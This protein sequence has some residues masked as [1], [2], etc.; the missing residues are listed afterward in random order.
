MAIR[1]IRQPSDTPNV[2]NSDDARMV[3]YA[4]G[5][6]DGFVLN[7]GSELSHTINGNIFKINSG[8]VVLQ[9]YESELDSNGWELDVGSTSRYYSVYYEVNLATQTTAIKSVYNLSSYPDIPASDD[10]T[11]SA[12]GIAYLLLYQ[13]RVVNNGITDVVKKVK[14]IPYYRED[15]EALENGIKDGSVIAYKAKYSE[16]AELSDNSNKIATTEF[17]SDTL[18]NKGLYV[19]SGYVKFA[20]KNPSLAA[21]QTANYYFISEDKADYETLDQ[22][23]DGMKKATKDK[24]GGTNNSF[25]NSIPCSG[26]SSYVKDGTTYIIISGYFEIVSSKLS[27]R[28]CCVNNNV[29]ESNTATDFRDGVTPLFLS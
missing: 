23:R 11:Q 14:G 25:L 27:V 22:L 6:Y 29:V 13:F 9:G 1:F 17:V 26:I 2:T 4:Y 3:R 10:L 15:I 12:N 20:F 19:H 8:V 7:R 28:A 21:I 18:K 24:E 5:G 16:T